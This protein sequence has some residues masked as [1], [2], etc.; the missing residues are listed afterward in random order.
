MLLTM[1]KTEEVSKR[2]N[3]EDASILSEQIGEIKDQ[4]S[5]FKMSEYK[6]KTAGK[7]V[8]SLANADIDQMLLCLYEKNAK[9]VLLGAETVRKMTGAEGILVILPEKNPE[10][11]SE[12][13]GVIKNAAKECSVSVDLI[14]GMCATASY[15]DDII[16]HPL[17]CA[18]ITDKLAGESVD[19]MIIS[20]NGEKPQEV[21]Y[22]TSLSELVPDAKGIRVG[23]HLYGSNVR[24]EILTE[25]FPVE[26]GVFET[27]PH[28]NCMV[29]KAEEMTKEMRE[30][31][32]GKC[33]FCREGLV[34]I[35]SALLDLMSGKA[36]GGDLE[37]IKEIGQVMTAQSNCSLGKTAAGAAIGLLESFDSEVKAHLAGKCEVLQCTPLVHYY[38]DQMLCKGDGHCVKHCPKHAIDGGKGYIGVVD[39]YEC[40]K[41]G[42]CFTACGNHAVKCVTGKLPRLPKEP[43]ALNGTKVERTIIPKERLRVRPKVRLYTKKLSGTTEGTENKQTLKVKGNLPMKEMNADV[44]I[45]AA[46]PA[47]LA[48]AVAA[49]ENNLSSIIFEKSNTTGGAANMGMGPLGID[50]KVQRKSF[51]QITVEKAF[52]MHMD[53]THWRVDADLVS[54]YFNKSGETIEWLEDMGVEFAGAFKYFAESEATWHIVKPENGVIGPRAAGGMVKALT[55]RAKELGTQ[56]EM[57][58][59]VV[60]LIKEGD[61]VCGVIAVDKDGQQIKATGKAVIVATGGFGN[62]KEMLE[63]EFNLHLGEDYYPFMIPGIVGDGLKMMW[64]AGAM[65]YGAGIEAIYQ[66]PDNLNWFLLDAVLRQPN[67]LINQLGERFMNEDRMGNTTFTGN[68]LALQPGNY[69]YCIMDG[70]ILKHYKKNG[71]DLE[72]IVHPSEAFHAFEQQAAVAVEQGYEAYTEAE[73]LDEVAKKLQIDADVLKNTVEVYNEMCDLHCDTQFNKNPK[74]LHKITGKGK[75]MVGKFFL[76][77]YGTIGGVRI[78]KYCEV[79]DE[80]FMPIEGLYSAGSDANTIYGD[81]YNFTLPGNTMG[82]AVNSGR[83][84]GEAVAEFVKELRTN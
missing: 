51:S 16:I 7:I 65:K 26:N 32:C 58:T 67:L 2:I 11:S 84:A 46:G 82:F 23:N 22:Q 56:F 62:N 45:V 68:A 83:M 73:T 48:A 63:K 57:E 10:E 69:A 35:D 4:V 77:A 13:T 9:G 8:V 70:A 66:L 71:P 34:Q 28:E 79:L 43:V 39:E 6:G 19:Y 29:H 72:D 53:Y 3:S 38:I 12:L 21:P 44:I 33:V 14:Y 81:S 30:R 54:A 42:A 17:T 80:G 36:R 1:D 75:Y 74:F 55:N 40:I 25:N 50:T 59:A 24:Q 41:C 15:K 27:F 20:V 18:K 52:D 49:G 60:E 61:K 78:N 37:L 76:G 5:G 31:S 47:G 64:N